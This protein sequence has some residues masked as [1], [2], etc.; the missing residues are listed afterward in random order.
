MIE[1]AT[2]QQG[3]QGSQQRMKRGDN[4]G[5]EMLTMNCE[6]T[7]T[8]NGGERKVNGYSDIE[9]ETMKDGK[10]DTLSK[11]LNILENFR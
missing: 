1:M 3:E 8:M 6:E 4:N 2:M 10:I 9:E 7:T 11:V 5:E